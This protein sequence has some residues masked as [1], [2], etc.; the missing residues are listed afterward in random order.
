MTAGRGRSLTWSEASQRLTAYGRSAWRCDSAVQADPLEW[1]G[2]EP[3]NGE[4][5]SAV[6]NWRKRTLALC[7]DHTDRA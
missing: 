7:S 2:S 1:N 3:D 4:A 5:E 6:V